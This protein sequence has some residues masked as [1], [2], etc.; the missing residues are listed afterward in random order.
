VCEG[1]RPAYRVTMSQIAAGPVTPRGADRP[2]PQE[3]QLQPPP[4][5]PQPDVARSGFGGQL[6][7]VPMMLGMGA[8]A[9]SSMAS[10][11]GA[12]LA[13][14][15]VLFGGVLIGV[16]VMTV[17]QG[18]I[19]RTAQLNVERRTYMRHLQQVRTQVRDIAGRQRQ[20][21]T[22]LHPEPAAVA[23]LAQQARLWDRGRRHPQ[24]GHVRVAT[25]PQRLACRLTVPETAPLED[26]DP[27]CASALRRLLRTSVAVA[28]LPVALALPTIP[29]LGV[30]G[31]RDAATDVVRAIVAQLV[32]FHSPDDVRLALCLAPERAAVWNWAAWLPHLLHPTE[33]DAAGPVRQCASSLGGVERLLGDQL[34]ERPRFSLNASAPSDRPHIVVVV[35]G[36]DLRGAAMLG[37]DAG[38][39]GVTIIQLG[40]SRSVGPHGVQLV[41]EKGQLGRVT[42]NGVA[43]V[44]DA[45]RM[46]RAA[47]ATLARSLT[48]LHQTRRRAVRPSEAAPLSGNLGLPELLGLG[49]LDALDVEQTQRSRTGAQRLRIPFGVDGDG[50]PV[51]LDFKE[52]AE[53]G[54]GPHGLVIGATG[55][56][57]SEMLRTLVL[58]LAATHPSETLNLVLVDF[59][60]GATFAGLGGLP[61]T[62]AVITN[63]ADDDGMVNRMRDA[64][65]GELVRR[66]EL[67]RDAG[68]Y[69]SVRDYE[70]ARAAGADLAPVPSLM[71]IIDEFSELL[72]A[73]PDFIDLFVMI[74]RLGRSLGVHLMLASQRLEEGRLRGLD[75]HLSYRVGLRTFSAS[76]SRSV[77]G[78][79]D[80]A[81]LP[82]VPGSGYLRIDTETLVRFKAAYVSGPV[83]RTAARSVR[84]R[85][86]GGARGPAAALARVRP[87]SLAPQPLPAA[88]RPDPAA[89]AAAAAGAEADQGP[90]DALAA[91]VTDVMVELLEPHGVPPHQVWLPPL[92]EAPALSALLPPLAAT[93]DRGLCPA[94]WAG[95]GQLS[96]P[97]ALVDKP[98]QQRQ[99]LLWL[100][101]SEAAGHVAV[102]GGPRSGKSTLLRT[103]AMSLAL[104]HTP[105][106]VQLYGLDFAGGTLAALKDLPHVGGVAGRLQTDRASRVVSEVAAVIDER[107]QLFLDEGI[108]S[109]A[110]FRRRRA[111]GERL[112]KR[113]LG[114]VFLFVDGWLI[115]RDDFAELY[116]R[117]AALVSRGLT[118]GVHVVI[119]AQRWMEI[120]PQVK[121]LLG[122]RVELRLGDPMDSEFGRKVAALV[123]EGAPGRG[124]ST[125]KLHLLAALPR[126]DD[127][128]GAEG[129]TAAMQDA[130]AAIAKA[131]TGPPAAPVRMLP[132]RVTERELQ[133]AV[134][135]SGVEPSAV[136]VPLG[137]AE[138][139]LGP[140]FLDLAA[141]PHLTVFGDQGSGKTAL[142][143]GLAAQV[144]RVATPE[145]AKLVVVDYRR[146]LLGELSEPHL[147][148]LAGAA[149]QAA[150]VIAR[151][152]VTMEMRIPGPDV[153]PAELKARSWWSGPEIFVLVDDYDLVA[154]GQ[155]DPMPTLAEFLPQARDLGLHVIITRRSAGA[156]R[157]SYGGLLPQLAD[158]GGA[159]LLMSGSKDEGAVFGGLKMRPLPPGRG[160]LLR[161]SSPPG[162]VQLPWSDPAHAG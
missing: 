52:S 18:P 149:P 107:E 131:W 81:T 30:S 66:Q 93:D 11:G 71:V 50:Q 106:E 31:E 9:F 142:L 43:L 96:V 54:M 35:D 28:D 65:A 29:R 115:L 120:R 123:P 38:V 90:D 97:V 72:S 110:E 102:V 58:G 111:A 91:T 69:A 159:G 117:V 61:H 26:L 140:L 49:D 42:P 79:P 8:M 86:V 2:A 7:M 122:S 78:V 62:A 119:T 137:I 3:I 44:G 114:D 118:Y 64:L 129:A 103:V 36:G 134:A 94:G 37:E 104:T 100:K 55:S 138:R 126:V 121:D 47:S 98:Y 80:A 77:L 160:V 6:M 32:T 99:D 4:L 51:E 108:D 82:S 45:D 60:G 16:L 88:P 135:A 132:T 154:T 161:R 143:R 92:E 33:T 124:M 136:R 48:R 84:D 40:P 144:A 75:S 158:A 67:L 139:D 147:V 112:G 73:E 141:E 95:N 116:D 23:T 133:D 145:Q 70:R 155:G 21:S 74:G 83:P 109:M 39:A 146:G 101:L 15:G 10:R 105:S 59:K 128:A 156:G 22:R 130:V 24:F 25:G 150:E 46:G 63:L 57:K 151:V 125:E 14:F 113:N 56:G 34:G 20:V 17:G 148:G 85:A 5:T 19:M 162:L 41:I 152:K 13:V 76:E 53:G 1:A 89:A 127:V 153:T 157:S 27:L 12:M 87:F 68:N